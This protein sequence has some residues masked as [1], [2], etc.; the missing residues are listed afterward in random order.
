[1]GP[2]IAFHIGY[3]KTAST[4][5][6]REILPRHP[7][8]AAFVGG[9]PSADPFLL[10]VIGS[11]DRAFDPQRARER[12]DARVEQ[13]DVP[14]DG[15]VLVSAERL[16]GHAATGG[17]DAFRI[18]ARLSAVVPD[19]SVFF[20]VREQVGMIES[21]YRQLVLEGSPATLDALVRR[22]PRWN[23]VGFDL[24][25]YEYDLL[26][27]EYARRFG[28]ARV[29]CF[30]LGA[31]SAE[32][33]RFLD[34]LAQ[35]LGVA[36][37]PRLGDEV[38]RRRVNRGLPARLV[39]VRRFLNHFQRSALNP[40]PLVAVRPFWSSPLAAIASRL[41][42]RRRPLLDAETVRWLRERYQASNERL[43][44]RYGVDLAATVADQR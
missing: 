42:P 23:T 9:P 41:P 19:A 32:P 33:R 26:A 43:A 24:G 8:I 12:F 29:R 21:E 34:D 4:W 27:D 39:G 35:F 1:M 20:V 10:D 36:P 5:F 16:S 18:A 13:L 38:L 2:R 40:Y 44:L 11:P 14:D 3:H 25:H 37:W 7:A 22:P 15:I 31:I 6:Q 17:Y 28:A 30:G